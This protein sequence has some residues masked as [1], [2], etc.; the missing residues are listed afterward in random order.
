MLPDQIQNHLI[1][2]MRDDSKA[3]YCQ[4]TTIHGDQPHVRTMRL[5][6]IRQD[7][8]VYF[9]DTASQKWAD[10]KICTK[11]A[12]CI[13]REDTYQIVMEGKTDLFTIDSDKHEKMQSYW[14]K[15]P[16]YWQEYYL[17]RASNIKNGIPN[18]FGVIVFSPQT[19]ELLTLNREDYS[20]SNRIQFKREN[21]HWIS[22]Q[23][24]AS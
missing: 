15:L 22:N 12:I 14:Q 10:L 19:C 11:M 2:W 5:Y 24:T 1:H 7:D 13:L 9:T 20:K 6:D 16:P 3:V 4:V 17:S 23:L 21:R 18:Q 8:L